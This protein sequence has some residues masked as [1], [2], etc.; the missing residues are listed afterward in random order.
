MRG[1][2]KGKIREGIFVREI[3]KG[4]YLRRKLLRGEIFEKGNIEEEYLRGNNRWGEIYEGKFI[5]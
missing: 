3:L 4:K 2:L 5:S 1:K